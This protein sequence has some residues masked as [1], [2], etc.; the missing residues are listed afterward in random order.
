MKKDKYKLFYV[1]TTTVMDIGWQCSSEHVPNQSAS[2]ILELNTW[3][4]L[5]ALW[6]PALSAA[7]S[8]S[9]LSSASAKAASWAL[10]F[11]RKYISVNYY[12]KIQYRSLQS[13]NE[14]KV[15]PTSIIVSIEAKYLDH[16][17]NMLSSGSS[18]SRSSPF[19]FFFFFFSFSFS[20][21]FCLRKY[22]SLMFIW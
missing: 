4:M 8:K 18:S 9:S 14:K 2:S 21:S 17:S 6:L 11:C 13:W 7:I 1:M 20:S 12:S 10:R 15:P 5:K 19:F 22:W 16:Q 3:S